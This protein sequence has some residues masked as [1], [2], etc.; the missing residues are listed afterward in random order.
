MF[1]SASPKAKAGPTFRM[2]PILFRI[3]I[4]F[5]IL[6]NIPKPLQ[7]NQRGRKCSELRHLSRLPDSLGKPPE[8]RLRPTAS[9]ASSPPTEVAWMHNPL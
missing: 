1:L 6:K 8:D 4:A 9:P 2:M 5:N 3:Y 7:L